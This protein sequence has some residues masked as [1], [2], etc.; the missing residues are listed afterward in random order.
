MK[1]QYDDKGLEKKIKGEFYIIETK[2]FGLSL[3]FT[4]D[5]KL[6]Y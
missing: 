2:K 4:P 3:L 5:D 6:N 1:I